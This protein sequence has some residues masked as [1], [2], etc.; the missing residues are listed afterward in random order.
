EEELQKTQFAEEMFEAR[1]RRGSTTSE[2]LD[3]RQ[4]MKKESPDVVR[5]M[6]RLSTEYPGD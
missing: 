5:V 2:A 3:Q 1:F 4:G 6:L